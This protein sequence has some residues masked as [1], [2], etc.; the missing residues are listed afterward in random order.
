[1]RNKAIEY[2]HRHGLD[3]SR[4]FIVTGRLTGNEMTLSTRVGVWRWKADRDFETEGGVF[5]TE[6]GAEIA[7]EESERIYGECSLDQSIINKSVTRITD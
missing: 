3:P 4:C 6:A 2:A 7:L 5:A 1:M